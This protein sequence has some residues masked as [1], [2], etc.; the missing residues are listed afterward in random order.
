MSQIQD[1]VI[2]GGGAAGCA[3]SYYLAK[4]GVKS[5]IIER[6]GIA[7][8]ASGYSAGG[9]N[10]LEGAGIPG[11][12]GPL[13]IRSYRMHAEIAPELAELSGVDFGYKV[14]SSVRVVLDESEM[15][16]IQATH[17]TFESADDDFSAEWL[18]AS[19][20]REMEPRISGDAI[21]ALDTRGN[22]ILS[23]HRY[24]LALAKSAETMGAK[25][26]SGTVTGVRTSGGRVSAVLTDSDEI[27]CDAVVF[28]TGPWAG[29]VEEW[30]G[31]QV[32][33]EPFKGEILRMKLDGPPLDRDFHSAA[34]DLN[35]REDGQIWVGATEERVGFD[36]N[37][38]AKA[39]IESLRTAT[40]LMPA[41]K[42]AELVLHT[43]CLR[44]LSP[45]WMPIVGNAP[46]W[47]NAYLATGAGKKGI[48]I[49]PGMGKAVADLITTGATDLPIDGF[50]ADR[51]TEDN[52]KVPSPS[53]GSQG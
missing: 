7:A 52:S 27:S 53:M 46:G 8:N 33:I 39:R 3:A 42:D 25:V 1:V 18:D 12:L 2:V 17:D 16:E 4:A 6:D 38:S 30:L 37:P 48:L 24:T 49:S 21:R 32:P 29:Q 10:P 47:D 22:A 36:R 45:D 9:L 41:I 34:V 50:N 13:A 35:H 44:P 5:I 28:A 11:P 51:F 20:L 31:V 23:S 14:I 40:N 43:A 15:A 26:V 19:Q